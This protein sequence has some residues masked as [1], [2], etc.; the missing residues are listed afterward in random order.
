MLDR[1]F[2]ANGF[3]F[4]DLFVLD[5]ANNHQ[6]SLEHGKDIISELSKVIKNNEVKA[7]IKF[8]FRDL[9]EFVHRDQR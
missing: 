9:P 5:M 3:N 1:K 4:K 2:I 8:Q 6:G 7:G